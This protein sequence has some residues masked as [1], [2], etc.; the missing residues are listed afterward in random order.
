MTYLVCFCCLLFFHFSNALALVPLEGIIL[1]EAKEEFQNDPLAFVF[2]DIYDHSQVG[3]TKKMKLYQSTLMSGVKLVESCSHF[4]PPVYSDVESEKNAKR[5]IAA[6]LQ[7][8]GLDTSIRAIGSY[9]RKFNL[10]QESFNQLKNNL[11]VNYCSKNL[12]VYSLKMVEKSL[13]YFFQNPLD[14]IIPSI[15]SSTYASEF[16]KDI[17]EKLSSRSKEFDQVIRSFRAFCSWGNDVDKYRMLSP[18]LSNPIIMAF[19][20][21]NMSGLKDKIDD[22]SMKVVTL[23]SESSVKVA[24]DNLVCRQ[25]TPLNFKKKFPRTVGSTGLE[26]DL[27]KLYCHHFRFRDL[28]KGSSPQMDAWIKELSLEDPVFETSNFISLMTGV[29]NFFNG[30]QNYKD[31]IQ[32]VKSSFNDRWGKWSNNML[33]N[34]STDLFYE[35]P[36]KVKIEPVRNLA[37]L[38]IH[39]F[40]INLNVTLGEIDR[41][42]KDNDKLKSKFH[43]KLSKNYLRQIRSKIDIFEKSVDAESVDKLIDEVANYLK[44]QINKK[45]KLFFQKMWTKDFSRIVAEELVQQARYYKGSFFDTYEDQ[46]LKIPVSF[47]Y[48]LFAIS[49][50]RYRADLKSGRVKRNI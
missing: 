29:P 31:L 7:Y 20:F 19:I 26:T 17:S 39:G 18:Y 37:E 47:S 6:T 49:Y 43:L 38:S 46:M 28:E 24:C 11:V 36:L 44:I 10:D 45:E 23:P 32:V 41:V 13:D 14:K 35:E 5:S 40:S 42:L 30:I 4:A 1:G 3:E 27:Q 8:I 2:S 50:I 9:A 22:R 34:F 21:K 15:E 16:A 33:T 48:G 12:T 25:V